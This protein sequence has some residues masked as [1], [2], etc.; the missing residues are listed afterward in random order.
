MTSIETSDGGPV[1]AEAQQRLRD[2]PDW[3]YLLREYY[4]MYRRSSAGGS[5]RIR[6]HQRV[7]RET[8][9]KVMES[10]P[11]LTFHEPMS[12]PVCAH[13]KR[14]LDRGRLQ[15]T[16]TVIRAI[17]SVS[18]ELSWVYGYDRVPPHLIG[19]FAYAEVLGP[20]GPVKSNKLILGLVLFG[21]AKVPS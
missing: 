4:E 19:K 10:N 16:A 6:A 2:A 12:K 17:E 20:S 1:M 7:V 11:S 5:Q 18:E 21:E 8:I 9:S 3:F 14:V 13:L 15:P